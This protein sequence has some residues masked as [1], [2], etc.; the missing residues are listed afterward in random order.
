[1]NEIKK[2]MFLVVFFISMFSFSSVYGETYYVDTNG[3]DS[4]GNGRIGT[5]WKTVALALSY[6]KTGDT[7]S[8]NNGIY[9][10]KQ[11][12]VPAAVNIIS[13]SKDNKKVK[14]KPFAPLGITPFILLSTIT[15]G[16]SGNQTISHIDIDGANI[17]GKAIRVQNRNNVR[18]H[19][20]Y[21][22]DF[23]VSS[24]YYN[25][26]EVMSTL[27]KMSQGGDWWS[28]W[29]ADPQAPG[30]DNN[31]NKLWPTGPVENF[32]F[33]NNNIV[34]TKGL[35][36]FNLKNSSIHD[37]SFNN[38]ETYEWCLV[39]TPAFLE[40]V[41]I[42]KNTFYSK[43]HTDR[44]QYTLE[45]WNHRNGCE[46]YSNV[47]EGFFSIGIGK[48]TNVYNNTITTS[49]P[50]G[51][52]GIEFNLQSYSNIY[53]NIIENAGSHGISVGTGSECNSLN[54]IT[55]YVTIENNMIYNPKY[56][57]ILVKAEGSKKT[58]NTNKTQYVNIYNNKIE[59]SNIGGGYG[60]FISAKDYIGKGVIENV[61]VKYN[62]VKNMS[63]AGQSEGLV[64]NLIIE[65]S[66]IF[67][68]NLYDQWTG[69]YS[70]TNNATSS[71][72]STQSGADIG[73]GANSI[74][75]PK[76]SNLRIY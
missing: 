68:N 30:V 49:T 50:S 5:P 1:M 27:P 19:N 37:N 53:N 76:P 40:N 8:V 13:T 38:K 43:P 41:K 18:I 23:S 29:P 9:P 46:Y 58:A 47:S 22:H 52:I 28:Y 6:A 51:G 39:G 32:E 16:S 72:T 26:I 34:S 20:C 12:I 11:L 45:L 2:K 4:T 64:K 54:Y 67:E 21:I 7:I 74:I 44:S 15:P 66:N 24:S 55:K 73:A 42:Y 61:N 56:H 14:L 75:P 36:L 33:D 25:T 3:N 65:E 63:R 17:A 70:S 62:S 69:V 31:I 60:I 10:E 48:E 35:R 57:G 71:S 59:S